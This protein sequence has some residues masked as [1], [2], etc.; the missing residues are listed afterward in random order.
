[1]LAFLLFQ[2]IQQPLMSYQMIYVFV[3]ALGSVLFVVLREQ[4]IEL[5]LVLWEQLNFN[6][7]NVAVVYKGERN[8]KFNYV[9]KATNFVS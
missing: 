9:I 6:I 4:Q 5:S 8:W 7:V 2:Q 1:M 3:S